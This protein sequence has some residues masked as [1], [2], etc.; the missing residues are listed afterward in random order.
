MMG[1]QNLGDMQNLHTH[2]TYCDGALT[3]EEMVLAAISRGYGSL[4]FSEHSSVATVVEI[5]AMSTDTTLEYIEEINALKEKYKGQIEIFLG[6]EQ[7]IF[8]ESCP[9]GLDYIIGTVHH[10]KKE[11]GILTVDAGPKSQKK[12][13]DAFFGGDY[14]S[15]AESYFATVA[16]VVNKT[17]ATIVGHFDLVTKYNFDGSQF[18][19][20]HRRYIY[21][22]LDAMDEIL[23]RCNLFEVN[24]GAMY[25]LRKPEPY[26]SV[27]FLKEL[28]KRG[29]E[30]I[31][32][33]DSHDAE[34]LCYKFDEMRELLKTLGFKY[35]K[36]LTQSGFIDVRL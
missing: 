22:A 2:T 23:K 4:G 34:S 31:L 13:V 15:M 32:S 12:M 33:S 6:I 16:E 7:D 17:N 27:F 9:E 30:V 35:M 28:L 26:P 19:Q 1:L 3:P 8:T 5:Y 18:D 36:R 25:R 21:S 11:G 24:T 29:G 14:Y 20:T 10:V